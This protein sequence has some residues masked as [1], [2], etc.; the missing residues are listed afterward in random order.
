MLPDADDRVRAMQGRW[1]GLCHRTMRSVLRPIVLGLEGDGRHS[2]NAPGKGGDGYPPFDVERFP[3]G[4]GTDAVL[5]I[6]L[7]VAG[8][9]AENLEISVAHN[10]LVIRGKQ[11]DDPGRTYLHRGIAARRFQRSFVLADGLEVRNARLRNGL[12]AIDLAQ[13]QKDR[14]TRRIAID[15]SGQARKE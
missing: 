15:M 8:F 5:R 9:L 13:P 3:G 10:Q 2:P 1:K 4:E 7:A 12:L 6:T 14:V 11:A